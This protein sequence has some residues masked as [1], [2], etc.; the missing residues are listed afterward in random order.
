MEQGF[1][2]VRLFLKIVSKKA[3]VQTG[4]KHPDATMWH[5]CEHARRLFQV[6]IVGSHR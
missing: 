6:A 5:F 2:K 1:F 4:V 3:V